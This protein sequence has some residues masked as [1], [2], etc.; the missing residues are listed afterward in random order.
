MSVF[1]RAK[2][3]GDRIVCETK[4]FPMR[5]KEYGIKVAG[6]TFIDGLIPPE[7]HT[8]YISTIEEYVNRFMEPIVEKYCDWKPEKNCRIT[9]GK[10]P[11]WCC[12]WQGEEQMP[13]LV[14][15][16]NN[17][18]RQLLP[19]EAEL[20]MLTQKNYL[21]YV[22]LPDYIMEKFQAGKMSITALSDV[23]RV[24]LLA[25]YGGFWIDSTVFISDT[26]PMEFIRSDFYSQR[27]FD[28]IKWKREAC[29]GRW[30]GF[31]MGG[32]PGN[33]IFCLLRDAFFAWWKIHDSVI[34]YVI[35]DYFLLAGYHGIPEIRKVIDNVP[36]NN[37]DVFE[38][39]KVLN[40]PYTSDLLEKLTK[41]TNLHK[42]TYK[43]DVKPYTDDGTLTLYGFLR[44][45]VEQGED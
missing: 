10:I 1:S 5:C 8:F 33:I 26:F 21:E 14:R 34:D 27:M 16:C 9:S 11:V 36:D 7:K 39:Y 35:L 40:K 31:L 38:M 43:M 32:T 42:L 17:R 23:L 41:N 19:E 44:N 4:E 12:W 13:E 24:S 37:P 22:T 20:H 45:S 2:H 25:Q 6:A 15:M 30:C 28:P 29:K 3:L 18:L